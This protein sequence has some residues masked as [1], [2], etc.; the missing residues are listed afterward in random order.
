MAAACYKEAIYQ[1]RKDYFQRATEPAD[2]SRK[3]CPEKYRMKPAEA[4]AQAGKYA[5]CERLGESLYPV[6]PLF[7][8]IERANAVWREKGDLILMVACCNRLDRRWELPRYNPLYAEH[9]PRPALPA[10][11]DTP[12]DDTA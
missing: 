12:S 11:S 9:D 1:E 4:K 5:V 10:V 8:T 2:G 7:D 3:R 6:S